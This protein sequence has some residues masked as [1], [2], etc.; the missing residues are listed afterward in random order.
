MKVTVGV[1]SKHHLDPENNLFTGEAEIWSNSMLTALVNGVKGG[2]WH[3]LMDKVYAK[4]T[5]VLAWQKV[6]TNKGAAGV[7]AISLEKFESQAV[8]YLTELHQQLKTNQ[9]Q[10]Q[11]VKR[12]YIEKAN[13]GQRPLGIPTIKDRVVQMAMKMVL[14]PIF[15][16]EFSNNSYGFRP[17]RSAKDALRALDSELKSGKNWV[18][19]ADIQGYFDNIAHD[20]LMEKI[21]RRIADKHLLSLLE[22]YLVQRVSETTREWSPIKGS[23]QGAVLSPLLANIYLHDLDLQLQGKYSLVRYADDFV[24]L[25]SSQSEAESAL[26]EIQQWMESHELTLHPDKTGIRHEPTDSKGI[27]FLGYRFSGGN[28]EPRPQAVKGLKNKIRRHTRRT[29][30]CSLREIIR[31]LN[32][33]LRGWFEYFKHGGRFITTVI[34]GFVRRRL[35]SILRKYRKRSCGTGR[36]LND[37]LRWPNIYFARNG[38]FTLKEAHERACKSR[39]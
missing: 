19:D 23:P 38:L 2:K 18:V 12:I 9:Y 26:E 15:E 30:G 34:D 36:S 11:S 10:P 24:I 39:C 22:K 28:K 29:Q 6:K 35:R 33:I 37:H 20:K 27:E 4:R 13:G 25:C 17:N 5:L 14:E 16:R 7:D 3:R 32:P 21:R 1:S 8:K 31:K